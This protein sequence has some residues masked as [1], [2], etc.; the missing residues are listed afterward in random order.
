[1]IKTIWKAFVVAFSIYSKIPMPR[2]QWESDDMKYHLCFFPWVGAVIGLLEGAWYFISTGKGIGALPYVMV[3][4]AIPLLITGGFHVDGFMDTCDALHSY[5]EREKKLE[6]LKDPHI[7]AFAVICLV[8]YFLLAGGFLALLY[9]RVTDPGI[10]IVCALVFVLSR[11]LSG[12]GVVT[13]KGA[14][15]KGMLQTFS[16]TAV[17]N[18]VLFLLG[19]QALLCAG[20]MICVS[21]MAGLFACGAVLLVWIYYARMSEKEFGGITGD[22]AGYFVS[23]AELI[24]L[25]AV[26]VGTIFLV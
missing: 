4:L 7:G 20:G 15:K 22:L 16:E 2:F 19:L 9:E 10:M 11:A 1:M 24:A 13:M 18:K 21:Y 6:I 3:A 8:I 23:L 5:Q 12:I 25:I 14:K 17:K 26:S